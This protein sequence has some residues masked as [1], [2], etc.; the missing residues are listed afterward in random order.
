MTSDMWSKK[1]MKVNPTRSIM[2]VLNKMVGGQI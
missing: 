1:T 2:A